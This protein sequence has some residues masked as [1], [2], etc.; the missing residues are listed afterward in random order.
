MILTFHEFSIQT[1]ITGQYIRTSCTLRITVMTITMRISVLICLTRSHTSL[2][3]RVIIHSIQATSFTFTRAR[4]NDSISSTTI[5][6]AY[7]I[8]RNSGFA[9]ITITCASTATSCTCSFASITLSCQ[10]ISIESISTIGNTTNSSFYIS[11]T[12]ID[13]ANISY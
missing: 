4:Y 7:S 6:L 12:N 10:L 13:N 2:S 8:L 5:T 3:C 11:R 1:S 9:S